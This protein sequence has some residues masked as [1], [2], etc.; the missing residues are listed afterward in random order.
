M[1]FI[2]LHKQII[3]RYH[4]KIFTYTIIFTIMIVIFINIF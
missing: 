4:L 2:Y 1:D 3:F